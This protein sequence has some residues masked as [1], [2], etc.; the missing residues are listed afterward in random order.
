M[1]V[2]LVGVRVTV[3][4]KHHLEAK[5]FDKRGRLISKGTNSYVK[6]HPLQAK[7][8]KAT[9]RPSAVYLHAEVAAIA[10]C[11]SLRAAYRIVVARFRADGTTG[12]A[13]PCRACQA[14]IAE[15]GIKVTEHT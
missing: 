7:H 10:R 4:V 8:A 3:G 5:I 9:G 1:F 11:R 13:K 14:A 12:C 6:T 15:A 2:I